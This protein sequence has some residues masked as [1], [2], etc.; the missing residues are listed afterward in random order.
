IPLSSRKWGGTLMRKAQPK[1][2]RRNLLKGALAG[3]A[4]LPF[5]NADRLRAQDDTF[6]T[7]LIVFSTPNGTRNSLFWPTAT[8]TGLS[9]PQ[10]TAP[11]APHEQQL[12]F[13]DG[14]RHC[15]AVVGDNGF[16]GGLN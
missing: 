9:F 11:L 10:L 3:T 8:G 2:H 4:A 6:P 16:N 14:I 7:R 13:L 15:P 5:L 1:F 12:V